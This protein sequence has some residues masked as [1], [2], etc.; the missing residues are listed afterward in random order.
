ML[1]PQLEFALSLTHEL[2]AILHW[3]ETNTVDN[4]HGGFYGKV[5]VDNKPDT[6]ANKGLILN[7]RILWAFSKGYKLTQKASYKLMA[8]RAFNVVINSFAD[9]QFGGYYSALT[10][11]GNPIAGDKEVIVHAYMLYAVSEY[12]SV[13]QNK[14][15]DALLD[16]MGVFI[17]K[18]FYNTQVKAYATL[19]LA[20]FTIMPLTEIFIGAQLHVLEAFANTYGYKPSSILKEHIKNGLQLLATHF[21]NKHTKHFNRMLD[22]QYQPINNDVNYGHN[23]EA[24]WLLY[25]AATKI[26][27]TALIEI[28]S[29]IILEVC[30][31]IQEATDTDGGIWRD[32]IAGN[33]IYEK[34]W[35]I[36]TEALTTFAYAYTITHNDLYLAKAKYIWQ[37]I[38]E[39]F[40]DTTYGEWHFGRDKNNNIM[41]DQGKADFWKCPYHNVRGCATLITLLA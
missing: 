24:A 41:Y 32:K 27:D 10:C 39:N 35:W 2:N 34:H 6:E 9:T 7:A 13:I 33:I 17:N 1:M 12:A 25:D 18:H 19:S 40:I 15:V 26:E 3:W 22:L 21:Y 38:Q 8:D 37:Y 31:S 29:Q 16:N 20:D 14:S 5:H 30:E 4:L 36:Q 28:T 11:N 23:M